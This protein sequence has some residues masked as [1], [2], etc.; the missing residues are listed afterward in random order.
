MTTTIREQLEAITERLNAARKAEEKLIS[1]DLLAALDN[2]AFQQLQKYIDKLERSWRATTAL[3]LR[4]E[5]EQ[6]RAESDI[7]KRAV[8]DTKRAKADAHRRSEEMLQ[9]LLM[10]VS[11]RDTE[12]CA[13]TSVSAVDPSSALERELLYRDIRKD[14]RAQ[15]AVGR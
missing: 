5:A 8:V 6:R 12:P 4:A 9:E 7:T 10:P 13:S 15:A 11:C 2:P 14:Q 1:D 3:L